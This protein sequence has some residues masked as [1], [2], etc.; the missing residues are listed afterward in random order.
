MLIQPGWAS[1]QPN[2]GRMVSKAS[3]CF[4]AGILS[5]REA[6]II[7][8]LPCQIFRYLNGNIEELPG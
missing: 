1:V 3:L 2:I 8:N 5:F 6:V 7:R 4:P